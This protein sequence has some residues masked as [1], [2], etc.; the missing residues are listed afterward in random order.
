[1]NG[2]INENQLNIDEEYEI[3]KPLIHKE[4]SI[5]D[6][7]LRDCHNKNFHTL[8]YKC[9]YD[10]Q[11]KGIGTNEIINLTIADKSMN[12]YEINKKLK[13]ARES[14]FFLIK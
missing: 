11:L 5:K 6:I 14:C 2:I 9:V 1:M 7:C 4:D 10:I 3:L 12:L 13:T 8:E